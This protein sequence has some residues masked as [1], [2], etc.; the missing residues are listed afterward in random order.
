MNPILREAA[1]SVQH[2]WMLGLMTVLFFA[3]FV[4]WIAWAW[5]PRNRARFEEEA[6][7]PFMDGGDQ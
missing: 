1:D 3:C 4:A 2:G 6:R 7:Q 5:A